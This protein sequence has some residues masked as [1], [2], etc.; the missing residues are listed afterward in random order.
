MLFPI[1]LV[2]NL[3]FDVIFSI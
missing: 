2:N 1:Q 3:I